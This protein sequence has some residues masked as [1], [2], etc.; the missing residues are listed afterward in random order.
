MRAHCQL[1]NTADKA[2]Q[3]AADEQLQKSQVIADKD[4]LEAKLNWLKD[5]MKA[6]EQA[7]RSAIC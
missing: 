1:Q 5:G 6:E 4:Q 3:L 7:Y 2:L